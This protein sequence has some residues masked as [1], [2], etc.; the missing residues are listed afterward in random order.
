MVSGSID[1]ALAGGSE[2]G[3]YLNSPRLLMTWLPTRVLLPKALQSTTV[4][5][6]GGWRYSS[7]GSSCRWEYRTFRV[8]EVMMSVNRRLEDNRDTVCQHYHFKGVQ[9]DAEVWAALVA[10]YDGGVDSF[11]RTLYEDL[12]PV[13]WQKLHFLQ[14]SQTPEQNLN[15]AHSSLSVTCYRVAHTF[16][17]NGS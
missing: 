11:S 5:V 8:R 16:M 13:D 2:G 7:S 4:I 10:L 3:L 9:N 14:L 17:T 1:G 12:R 6:S 15:P